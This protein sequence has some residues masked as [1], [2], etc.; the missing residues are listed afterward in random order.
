MQSAS[1]AAAFYRE[2][3]ERGVV[4]TVRDKNGFPAPLNSDGARAQPF[5]SSRARVERIISTVQ[6]YRGFVPVEIELVTFVAKWVPGL[7]KDGILAGINWTGERATGYDIAPTV[8][9]ECIAHAS[10]VGP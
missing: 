3:A 5:W 7:T 6:A 4:W 9:A 8:V 1:Q 2:V 10:R